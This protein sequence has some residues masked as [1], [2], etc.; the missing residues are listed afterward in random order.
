MRELNLSNNMRN[1]IL[2]FLC[3]SIFACSTEKKNQPKLSKEHQKALDDFQLMDGF[4]IEM[5]AAEPLVADPV[6]MEIDEDGNWF[7]LEMP[8]Y[9]LDLSKTGQVRKLLDTNGDGYPDKSEIFVDSL[10]LPMGIM[11]WKKG[12]IVADAPNI[13]YFEDTNGDNNADKREVILTGFSLSNPQHNMNSP[14]FGLD[15]W[16]YLGHSGSI[17]S[18]AY[19]YLFGDKGSDIRYP[20]NSK[21][22]VLPKNGN[23]RNVR[24]KPDSFG[25]ESMSGETQY[26]HTFDPWGHR[27]YT[28]NADHLYHE[29]LD[30]RY[31]S[32]NPNLVI[33]EAMEKIPDHGDACEVYPI[34]E[35]PNHQLLTDV[36]VV[37]SSC[38]ITWYDGG[39]FGKDF[40][41]VTFVG[42]PVHNLVHADIIEAK[43]ST[44]SGKRLLEK[45][46]FLAS[47][48]PWFRPV[49]FYVGPDGALYVIDYYRQLIEHPEWMSEE[50]NKS[51]AL[52]NG[53][54]KGRIYRITKKGSAGMNWMNETHVSKESSEKLV[55][56]LQSD[57]GWFRKTAQRLLFHRKDLKVVPA[58]QEIIANKEAEA[59][60]PALWLLSDW[61]KLSPEDLINALANKT[62]GVR[63]NALKIADQQ[64]ALP[65]FV[66]N[67]ELK[68]S[69]IQTAKD[70]D[71]RVRFQ[72]LCSSAFF[73]FPE[74]VAL[75]S[76][77]LNQDIDDHWV[78][79]AAIAAS[80]NSELDLLKGAI[81]HFG[82]KPSEGKENFFA[83]VAAALMKK[84][85]MSFLPLT[86]DNQVSNDWWQAAL[87]KGVANY[88]NYAEKKIALDENQKNALAKSFLISPNKNMR[89]AITGVFK[90]VGLPVD[91]TFTK[92]VFAKFSS[93][94][95]ATFQEDALAMLSLPKDPTFT[96]KLVSFITNS[97][98]ESIQ[99][100]SLKALPNQ[101]SSKE[102]AQ[103]N[104]VYQQM[105]MPSRKAWI[106]YQIVNEKYMI[107]LLKEIANKNIPK[108]DLEWPQ[109]VELMN[110]YDANIRKLAREVLAISEDRKAVLQNYLPAADMAGNAEKG[111]EI[112]K[113]NCTVC[114]QIKGVA[115]V[116][117]GPDLSTLKSRNALSIITE[118][119]NP[120]NSIADKYGN[121][122]LQMSD[123]SRLSGIITSE[124]ENSLSLKQ[125]GG[126]VQVI[127]KYRIK[128][129]VSSKV[130]AM[131]NGLDANIKLQDMADLVAFIKGI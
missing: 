12:I 105:K 122:D 25:L 109:F 28:D 31:T 107:P 85:D 69:L 129:R 81:S 6:A 41:Q 47:K 131:P 46:E 56:L 39:A 27:F 117:F 51:G 45:K 37:T 130:S 9:P 72:W 120:N 58:L 4:E 5:V 83:Y 76:G 26:G 123:G 17:N 93:S 80:K 21:A 86:S 89:H 68:E 38:G 22:N 111:K 78:G 54:T 101:I 110:S 16:I 42:E 61:G 88:A 121:W 30:A 67:K 128:S 29:V 100:A 62:A 36:G 11:K 82:N 75:R 32:T 60:V 124:N 19:E 125:M 77:I 94:H 79:V 15:N 127:E 116:S 106:R 52:Y 44:F 33:P 99:L 3:L 74:A 8:G 73:A 23:G 55:E 63:E 50:V 24:F 57:N 126:S 95:D 10:T 103:I 18:F 64:W 13:L 97:T 84:Q 53:K 98:S 2:V 70:P 14:K 35:N 1:F 104:Q 112:F 65:A 115:G 7:V 59:S 40:S 90:A 20:S 118:I 91:K 87:L 48:D 114:H 119:I 71:A 113:A 34:S 102:I 66:S 108:S 49:N 92:E 96:T 43:G